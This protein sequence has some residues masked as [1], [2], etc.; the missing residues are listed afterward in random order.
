MTETSGGNPG[1]GRGGSSGE[2]FGWSRGLVRRFPLLALFAALVVG[3]AVAVPVTDGFDRYFSSNSFCAT[4]CHVME[5]TVYKEFQESVHGTTKTGVRPVCADC[6]VS[7]NLVGA[8]WDH[9]VGMRELISFTFKGIRTAEDFEKVRAHDAERVRLAMFRAGSKNCHR[10]HVMEAIQPEKTRG[11]RQ[12][13]LAVKEGNSNCIECHYN[14]VH[15]EVEPSPAFLA[16]TEG[17]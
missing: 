17:K 2:R 9:M 4:G 6:H 3:A 13:E 12:H 15:K 10:C 16:A 11:K 14:L 7:E 8:M 5:S 1:V